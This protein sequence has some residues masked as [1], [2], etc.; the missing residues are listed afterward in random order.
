MR[1]ST[2]AWDVRAQPVPWPAE[3]RGLPARHRVRL[4]LHHGIVSGAIPGGTRIVQ[5]VVADEFAVSTR[6]VR[7]ALHDLAAEG[8]VRFDAR[9]TAVVN[10]LC[11]DDLEDIYQIRLLLEPIAVARSATLVREGTVIRAVKLLAA[12]ESETDAGR[13]TDFDTGFHRVVGEPGNSPRLAAILEN[14]RELSARYVQHSI[15]ASPDRARESNAEHEAIM[16]AVIKGDPGAAADAMFRHLD[17]TLSALRVR[18][19]QCRQPSLTG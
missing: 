6:Q 12:M 7:D 11:R 9:G 5:S 18:P 1:S 17:G 16:H 2:R 13:W 3:Q 10:E 15:L 8:F 4:A 19:V 14:L